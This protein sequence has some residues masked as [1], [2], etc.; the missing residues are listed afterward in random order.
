MGEGVVAAQPAFESP[1]RSS[2]QSNSNSPR[3]LRGAT[4]TIALSPRCSRTPPRTCRAEFGR[5]RCGRHGVMDTG[6][7]AASSAGRLAGMPDHL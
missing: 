7:S 2:K 4:V 5:A 1:G 3:M 6:V